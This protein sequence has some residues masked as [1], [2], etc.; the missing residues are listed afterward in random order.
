MI[1]QGDV[2][3]T[4]ARR[5]C[6]LSSSGGMNIVEFSD[7]ARKANP[8]LTDLR[9]TVA[10][11]STKAVTGNFT[12]DTNPG[13]ACRR[14]YCEPNVFSLDAVNRRG[15]ITKVGNELHFKAEATGY[16]DCMVGSTFCGITEGGGRHTVRYKFGPRTGVAFTGQWQVE[17]IS[18][19]F[20]FFQGTPTYHTSSQGQRNI[21]ETNNI[22]FLSSK[23][24]LTVIIQ[25]FTNGSSGQPQEAKVEQVWVE[26]Q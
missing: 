7:R 17:V 18:W 11:F 13:S 21:D 14:N 15:T 10:C 22:T 24:Y 20:G 6:D 8:S 12:T 4:A 2:V 25:A 23:P 19:P 16:N 9:G 3:L 1:S 26:K 5:D